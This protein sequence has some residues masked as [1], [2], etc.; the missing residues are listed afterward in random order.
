MKKQYFTRVFLDFFRK[1]AANNNKDWFEAN[2]KVFTEEVKKPFEIFVDDMIA[3]M[4]SVYGLKGLKAGDCVFRIYKDVRFSKDK[5]PYK[6][7]MSALITPGGRKNMSSPGLYIEFGP[8]FLQIYSGFYMPEKEQLTELRKKIASS[9]SQMDKILKN[10]K[11]IASFGEV[12]GEVSKILPADIKP[13]DG[14]HPL[15]RNKQFYL[16]HTAPAE[17]ILKDDLQK[18]ILDHY[19]NAREFNQFLSGK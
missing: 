2:K 7:Q 13:L 16:Q 19:E 10:K 5:T 17:T 4:P 12:K 9:P 15:V 6:T 3:A 14:K 8:E 18:Y 1:L 11:F